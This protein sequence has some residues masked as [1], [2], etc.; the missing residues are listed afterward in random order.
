[1]TRRS[2][3]IDL[4]RR[5]ETK[6]RFVFAG[7]LNTVFGLIIFPSLYVILAPLAVHYEVVLMLSLVLSVVFS[8]ATT[9]YFVFRTHGNAL[10]EFVRF[11]TFHVINGTLNL[12]ALPILVEVAFL[13]PVWAQLIFA[14]VVMVSSY[15]WHSRIS[16]RPKNRVQTP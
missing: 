14:T 3:L 2:A 16:F 13:H 1:M 11:S 15:F 7:G 10:G 5:H 12:L 4:L 8:F 6:V 9:K